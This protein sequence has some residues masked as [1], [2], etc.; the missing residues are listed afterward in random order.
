MLN[1]G[2]S[3][4]TDEMLTFAEDMH[5][6]GIDVRLRQ[7]DFASLVSRSFKGNYD[8]TANGRGGAV[9]FYA[10]RS[11]SGSLAMLAAMRRASSRVSRVVAERR[12]G[13]IVKV[14]IAE[15]L[16]AR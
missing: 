1:Q 5:D 8:M 4:I 13:F 10:R 9:A 15:R 12:C 3:I 11:N 14:E 7:L 6:V 16:S 2:S